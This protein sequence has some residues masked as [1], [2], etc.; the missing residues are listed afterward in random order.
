MAGSTNRMLAKLGSLKTNP[1]DE[2]LGEVRDTIDAPQ[3]KLKPGTDMGK[4]LAEILGP[5]MTQQHTPMD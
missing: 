4:K 3:L 2:P 1:T 5:S